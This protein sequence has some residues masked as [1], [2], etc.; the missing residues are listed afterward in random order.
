MGFRGIVL[1]GTA[2][3]GLDEDGSPLAVLPLT[4]NLATLGSD[5]SVNCKVEDPEDEENDHN[6]DNG[7]DQNSGCG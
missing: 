4:G 5:H 7:V 1:R 6:A 3:E 2:E